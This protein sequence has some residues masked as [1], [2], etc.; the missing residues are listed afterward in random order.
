MAESSSEPDNRIALTGRLV[1]PPRLRRSPAG[2]P[3][4][5]LLLEHES[6]QPEAG[7]Q[8]RQRF[9]IGV[10]ATGEE[11]CG[12]LAGLAQGSAVRVLG[13]LTRSEQAEEDYR[14]LICARRIEAL[15]DGSETGD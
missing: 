8:R 3:I 13:Y 5:R 6:S 4:A 15:A 2:I 14:L 1:E 10:R 7:V 12:Q 9:R 11:I